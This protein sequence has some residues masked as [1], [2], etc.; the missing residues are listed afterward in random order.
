M[1]SPPFPPSGACDCHVHV[2]GPKSL[3]PLARERR[4]TPMDALAGE[5]AAM[6]A[7]LGL[8]RVVLVQ[9]SFYGTDNS[10]M[11]DAMLKL[12][13]ARGVA[14]LPPYVAN[15]E[16]DQLHAR[17]IRGLRV[18][19]ATSGGA[20]VDTMRSDIKAAAALCERNGWH[21]QIFAPSEAIE[22]L[23]ATLRAL[24]V[25][26]VID[27][28][29]LIS[30]GLQTG[31]LHALQQLLQTGKIWVKISGAYR[32]ADDPFDARIGPLAL[33]L[34][35]ANPERIVWGSDWPHTPRH[36]ARQNAGDEELSFQ[37]I[38]THRLLDLVP[39]WLGDDALVKQVLV[40]NPARL[41]DFPAA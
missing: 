12:E 39:K 22:P 40:S 10:C 11:L 41:Y 19:I 31:A 7:A 6:L 38:E 9:P 5:L 33:R 27:H 24:P 14:V 15:L 29:G 34:C 18:N 23:A 3:F 16:L 30:P 28:F 8:Q 21:V 26:T 20:S 2:I 17:G 4:Y 25:D 35:E 1:P 37:M 32:I 13:D 36:D